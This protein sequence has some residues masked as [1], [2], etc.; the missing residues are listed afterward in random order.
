[1]KLWT[2]GKKLD[3]QI[4]E[5]TVGND[6]LYDQQLVEYDCLASSAHAELLCSKKIISD[7]E[8]K[9]IDDELNKII[10]LN[11]KGKFVV[12]QSDEDIHTKIENHLSKKLGETGKKIHTLRSR[13][14]QVLVAMQLYS[15][16]KIKET[17][18]ETKN[19]VNGLKDFYKKNPGIKMP[20]Y[21][22]MQKA[23]PYS[24]SQWAE[25]FAYSLEIDVKALEL[26]Y[27]LNDENP[28]GSAAGYGLPIKTNVGLT[29]KKLGFKK[30][31]KN[32]LY[33]QN[34]RMK[35][36]FQTIAALLQVSMTLNKLAS[37]L[38]LFTTSEFG[39]FSLP[40]EFCTGSSI[41]PQK[42]NYD[43]LEILRSESSFV[44]S[45]L[46]QLF[47][48]ANN[49]MSGYNRDHQQGK[50]CMIESFEAVI[51]SVKVSQKIISNLEVNK[52]ALEKAC[53]EEIFAAQKAI[54][55][56]LKGTPFREAYKKVCKQ[57]KKNNKHN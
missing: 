45:Q 8:L 49:L 42:N 34:T 24:V 30:H 18:N 16:K 26:A 37:D 29:T 5:F 21:T 27:E 23:M 10:E 32:A 39:F 41:M 6:Y 50:Q 19:L 48:T 52:G 11:K 56:S 47:C 55:L 53:S 7:K 25:S 46:S 20:G 22:H 54:E 12:K 14:D 4:E 31:F 2:N 57:N 3:K 44:F 35:K 15:K 9:A 17:I 38:M 33:V 43:V 36:Q 13:N 40:E 28:L 1:M 51:Q